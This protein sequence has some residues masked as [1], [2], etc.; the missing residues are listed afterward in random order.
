M[1]SGT[2]TRADLPDPQPLRDF[3]AATAVSCVSADFCG[4]VLGSGDVTFLEH[5]TWATPASVPGAVGNDISC[6]S[7]TF[8]VLSGQDGLG[9]A[10]KGARVTLRGQLHEVALAQSTESGEPAGRRWLRPRVRRHVLD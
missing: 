9:L 10:V 4:A 7:T 5:G 8:C 1:D 2:W 6:V 3:V